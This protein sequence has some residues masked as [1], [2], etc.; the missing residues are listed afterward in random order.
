LRLLI[1]GE[2]R[3]D[4]AEHFVLLGLQVCEQTVAQGRGQR[5]QCRE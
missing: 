2:Q 3:V 5:R 1:G 4:L